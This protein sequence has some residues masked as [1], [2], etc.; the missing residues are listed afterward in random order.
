M[1]VDLSENVSYVAFRT[2]V[3]TR[4]FERSSFKYIHTRTDTFARI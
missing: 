2:P 4:T 1:K 3:Y